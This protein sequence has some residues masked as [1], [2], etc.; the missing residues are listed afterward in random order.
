MISFS[1]RCS[2]SSSSLRRLRAIRHFSSTARQSN[3]TTPASTARKVGQSQILMTADTES[4]TES[5]N[6]QLPVAGRQRTHGGLEPSVS[7]ANS[8]HTIPPAWANANRPLGGRSFVLVRPA[9]LT[10]PQRDCATTLPFVRYHKAPARALRCPC[11]CRTQPMTVQ[12][13]PRLRCSFLHQV[14]ES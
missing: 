9:Y 8:S 12:L 1:S 3:P 2:K 13:G 5:A 6:C 11:A 10:P 4:T 7:L 14:S